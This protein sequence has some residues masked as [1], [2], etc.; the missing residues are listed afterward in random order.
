ETSEYQPWDLDEDDFDDI[1]RAGQWDVIAGEYDNRNVLEEEQR[2]NFSIIDYLR[3]LIFKNDLN[4]GVVRYSS[5]TGSLSEEYISVFDDQLH[6][7][8]QR[9]PAV[10]RRVG[11][12]LLGGLDDF[13]PSGFGPAGRR[14]PIAIPDPS[15][16][17]TSISDLTDNHREGCEAACWSGMVISHA[18]AFRD[19]A[20]R[21]DKVIMTRPVNPDATA[22]IADDA[23]TKGMNLKGKSSS[24]GPQKG[25]IPVDQRYSKIWLQYSDNNEKRDS[26]VMI[27]TGKTTKH[28]K[29]SPDAAVARHLQ[30]KYPC[31]GAEDDEFDVYF[32]GSVSDA[33]KS[34]FLVQPS[35][36]RF[37]VFL[38]D[39][40]QGAC[41]IANPEVRDNLNGLDSMYVMANPASELREMS[42]LPR[43]Y[44]A[45]YD[46]LAIGSYDRGL[47]GWEGDPYVV[48]TL[49][50][51]DPERGLITDLQLE[52]LGELNDAVRDAG[53]MGGDV[54]HHGP[55]NQ[56]YVLQ[57]PKDGSPYV[58]Y[59]I[60]AF[61]PDEN[62]RGRILGIPRGPV[63][64]RDIHLKRFMAQM[65]RRG[66]NL[67][68]NVASPGWQWSHH[69]KYNYAQGWDDRDAPNLE[70]SPEMI[71]FPQNCA[72]GNDARPKDNYY[73][74]LST[75]S[76]EP[77]NSLKLYPNPTVDRLVVHIWADNE[78]RVQL[79]IYDA[80]GRN[81]T[82]I[83]RQLGKG[84]NEIG[85]SVE[86]M[87]EGLYYLV[88]SGQE[89]FLTKQF[90]IHRP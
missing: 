46:L 56:F 53:Y 50:N 2:E 45:D 78:A 10:I 52:L 3:Y 6:S 62:G 8:V 34:V 7:F 47:A 14:L 76:L 22:L 23:A 49:R 28:L 24:W 85:I 57:K 70:P 90:V 63:G 11:D 79:H 40:S 4:D 30:V 21:L 5:Q 33:T 41:P 69:R 89:Q 15:E 16:V 64:Y 61:Y 32:D 54:S 18:Y 71:P 82:N 38:W 31:G 35:G 83:M 36:G 73:K 77:D 39:E 37:K 60:T 58:D 65:R 42:G 55:E 25:Y 88:V 68:E 66:Y 29:S 74:S 20:E 26:Q 84:T 13:N 27:F 81:H 48:D 87:P 17:N 67:Y 44:T 72:C 80:E 86:S 12:L 51:F 75:R 1:V 9:D 19:V 59:P 43:Y